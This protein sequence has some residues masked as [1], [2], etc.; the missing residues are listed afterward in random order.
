[1]TQRLRNTRVTDERFADAFREFTLHSDNDR[2]PDDHTDP[3]ARGQPK[4]G[5]F[6]L[7]TRGYRVKCAAKLLGLPPAGKWESVGT[8]HEAALACAAAV[9]GSV[10]L[11]R[12]DSGSVHL[13][14]KLDGV[15]HVYALECRNCERLRL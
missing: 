2:W 15:M 9:A 5:A 11:V 1:M 8:K 3:G 12:S 6:L 4:D 14:Q 10:V 7:S 13:V